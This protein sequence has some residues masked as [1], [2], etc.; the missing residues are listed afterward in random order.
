MSPTSDSDGQLNAPSVPRRK[1]ADDDDDDVP[2]ARGSDG[3]LDAAIALICKRASRTGDDDDDVCPTRSGDVRL[4]AAIA[5]IRKRTA[6]VDDDDDDVC[7]TSGDDGQLNAAIA[8]IRRR[9][10]R[11]NDDDDDVS[12]TGDDDGQLV[13]VSVRAN[14]ACQRASITPEDDDDV[15]PTCGGDGQLAVSPSVLAKR[16][17]RVE[18]DDDD[19]S[20]TSGG[21]G[22]IMA[23]PVRRGRGNKSG[24]VAPDINDSMGAK[25]AE[26]EARLRQ[27][28]AKLQ[29]AEE[30][31]NQS[32]LELM[33]CEADERSLGVLL[34]ESTERSCRKLP[35]AIGHAAEA[36]RAERLLRARQ[37]LSTEQA[38]RQM[39]SVLAKARLETATARLAEADMETVAA[40]QAEKEAADTSANAWAQV[41]LA[42]VRKSKVRQRA[43]AEAR[44]AQQRKEEEAR[45]TQARARMDE[46]GA[47]MQHLSIELKLCESDERVLNRLLSMGTT[48]SESERTPSPMDSGADGEFMSPRA[49]RVSSAS[50]LVRRGC[51]SR[52]AA[53][54]A[55]VDDE[56]SFNAYNA[57]ADSESFGRGGANMGSNPTASTVA[58]RSERLARAR[59]RLGAERA[60]RAVAV[61][62]TVTQREAASAAAKARLDA[63]AVKLVEA[64]AEATA[65]AQE[66]KE[67]ADASASAWSQVHME[68]VR[69]FPRDTA[70]QH[71]E[72]ETRAARERAQEEARLKQARAKMKGAQE[73]LRQTE[74]ELTLCK[75]EER[76]LR[77]AEERALRALDPVPSR[78]QGSPSAT[79]EEIVLELGSSR[80]EID[81]PNG[82]GPDVDPV[83]C[84]EMEARS[85]LEAKVAKEAKREERLQRARGRL[86]A[87][88]A[89]RDKAEAEA[90][91]RV[92]AKARG[93]ASALGWSPVALRSPTEIISGLGR[94]HRR[95]SPI[96]PRS[97]PRSTSS[98]STSSPLRPPPMVRED[99]EIWAAGEA[100]A[101]SP[102]TAV[103][104][105]PLAL[106][107]QRATLKPRSTLSLMP[108][109]NGSR[110]RIAVVPTLVSYTH[111]PR[112]RRGLVPRRMLGGDAGSGKTIIIPDS[113]LQAQRWLSTALEQFSSRREST[114]ESNNEEDVT[115]Q[116]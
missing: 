83:L 110:R 51:G 44:A 63:A 4:D 17:A 81:S 93:G 72:E 34:S 31:L 71:A 54:A 114:R 73:R 1:R 52:S 59:E 24:S 115:N 2:P 96:T 8:F 6:R 30:R 25:Y 79:S 91:A 92:E 23:A 38:R 16:A 87:E 5:L 20:P 39:A 77:C 9:A 37:H 90:N 15:A 78:Q 21:D 27:A 88:R 13:Y 65:A 11:T 66:E 111:E 41:H 106:T 74:R 47:S 94:V 43:E 100:Q 7:P 64:E 14:H 89:R 60:R 69:S 84:L 99:G 98:P 67:A 85:C 22:E 75:T 56:I 18:D 29:E 80:G 42:R 104:T 105:S 40:T 86:G 32:E 112:D 62:Q 46:A 116:V 10:A 12:P 97:K 76:A 101:A 58:M 70:A 19:I 55:D 108:S 102:D 3:Q 35:Q 28:E 45:L 50:P 48:E 33:L 57:G 53:P 107:A 103:S 49:P 61:A 82:A 36:L 109:I 95:D 68:R 113:A 26:N